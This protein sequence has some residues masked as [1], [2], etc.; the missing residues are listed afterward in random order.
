MSKKPLVQLRANQ[1]HRLLQ[2][3]KSGKR[4]ARE[5]LYAYILLRSADGWSETE[6]AKAF[7]IS[8]RTVRR[9][10]FRYREEGLNA[11]LQEQPRSGQ[12]AKLT[13]RQETLLV[14]L[15]CSQ[16]PNGRQ[17]W[18]VRLLTE[19]ALKRKIVK[20]I[21]PETARRVLKKIGSSPGG[22]RVG[23]RRKSRTNFSPD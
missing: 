9:I 16:P 22:S 17:R 10:R 3:V 1:R 4:K 5:I 19:Q 21:V 6:I 12:P 23:V 18:T 8:P 11:A 15:A 7:D 2:F 20:R 13:L 14:A